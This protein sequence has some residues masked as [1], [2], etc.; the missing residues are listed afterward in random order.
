MRV[1]LLYIDGCPNWHDCERRLREALSRLGL[2]DSALTLRRVESAEDAERIA[3]RGSPT[4][5]VNGVDAFADES[6]P[7]GLACRVYHTPTGIEA[8]PTVSQLI[9]A[10]TG[11]L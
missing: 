10:L 9:D 4:V 1:V 11:P 5:L 6:A 7:V 2:P 3:F 8:A